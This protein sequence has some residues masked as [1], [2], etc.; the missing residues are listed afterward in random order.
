V[1]LGASAVSVFAAA[2]PVAGLGST[3]EDV[4]LFLFPERAKRRKAPGKDDEI[5][6]L[7]AAAMQPWRNK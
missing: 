7:M 3:G 6:L 4:G 2:R 1:V 5:I